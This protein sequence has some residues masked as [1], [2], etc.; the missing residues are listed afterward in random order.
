MIIPLHF[1]CRHAY[2]GSVRSF[3][4]AV[5][6]DVIVLYVQVSFIFISF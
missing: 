1:K 4:T 3:M 5:N 2:S 6:T